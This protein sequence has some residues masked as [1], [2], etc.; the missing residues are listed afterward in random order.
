MLEFEAHDQDAADPGCYRRA[1]SILAEIYA[2]QMAT[3]L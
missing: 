1:A 2:S 3:V